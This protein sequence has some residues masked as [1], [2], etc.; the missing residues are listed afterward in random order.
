MHQPTVYRLF[1]SAEHCDIFITLLQFVSI[2]V[3]Q[4][5]IP[6]GNMAQLQKHLT[7]LAD[8]K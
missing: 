2:A 6:F 7:K 3:V 8:I 1:F 4:L 5:C